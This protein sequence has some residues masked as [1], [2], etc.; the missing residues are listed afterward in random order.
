MKE[1]FKPEVTEK[2]ISALCKA[3]AS[4]WI[5]KPRQEQM[6]GDVLLDIFSSQKPENQRRLMRMVATIEAIFRNRERQEKLFGELCDVMFLPRRG[7]A[8]W[9][10]L[11]ERN[12]VEEAAAPKEE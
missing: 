10:K 1:P 9:K 7:T 11:F 5:A 3:K 12:A 4:D 8:A 6:I 2:Q